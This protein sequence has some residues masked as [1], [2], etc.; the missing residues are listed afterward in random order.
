MRYGTSTGSY[1]R[2]VS[3]ATSYTSMDIESLSNSPTQY[4]F[5]V[6]GS[7]SEF[8]NVPRN[9]RT[10]YNNSGSV[11]FADFIEFAGHWGE[12][13]TDP[14]YDQKYEL[15]GNLVVDDP[16]SNI[17]I[18]DYNKTC[19]QLPKISRSFIFAQGPNR[20]AR[21][22]VYLHDEGND[23]VAEIHVKAAADVVGFE[24]RIAYDAKSLAYL[25]S[26]SAAPDDQMSFV[27]D[28]D[29]M[30]LVVS[31][32]RKGVSSITGD[33]PLVQIRF[34]KKRGGSSDVSLSG[35]AVASTDRYV[36]QLVS[37]LSKP[38]AD[39]FVTSLDGNQPN[40]FNPATTISFRLAETASLDLVIYNSLGQEVRRLASGEVFNSGAHRIVWDG[41]NALG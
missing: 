16:D 8:T 34:R 6:N 31:A 25:G 23:V 1:N 26:L 41:K 30:V 20:N 19:G 10:D 33:S 14:G 13:S 32:M 29:G 27:K 21:P 9:C 11:D 7:S 3:M 36:D 24:A 4:Y 22:L 18:G 38:F 12:I 35:L 15:S 5:K 39:E 17:F 40:P 2:Y 28:D 37:S